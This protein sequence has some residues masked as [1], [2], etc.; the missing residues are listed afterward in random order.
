[1]M[2]LKRSDTNVE[3]MPFHCNW[4]SLRG[5]LLFWWGAS[6][7]GGDP[8]K[9]TC[10]W[11]VNHTIVYS[12]AVRRW[13]YICHCYQSEMCPLSNFVDCAAQMQC[14]ALFIYFFQ[15]G[16]FN[17]Y[18]ISLCMTHLRLQTLTVKCVLIHFELINTF[19]T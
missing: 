16:S 13:R 17:T 14:F 7:G 15:C 4:T 19:Q 2:C 1:M 3:L 11:F 18:K 12:P 5:F 9:L 10:L 8:L 6:V